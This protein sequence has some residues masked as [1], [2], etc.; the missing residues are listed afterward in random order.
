MPMG[1]YNGVVAGNQITRAGCW[2]HIKRKIIDAEKAAP[3]VARVPVERA[4]AFYAVERHAK[5]AT[6]KERLRILLRES[7]QSER[8]S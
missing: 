8:E 1:G 4:R 5:D 6:A 7:L 2:A 3:E